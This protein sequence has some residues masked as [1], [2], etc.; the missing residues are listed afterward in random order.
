MSKEKKKHFDIQNIA[1]NFTRTGPQVGG[2]SLDSA[3][4]GS[5]INVIQRGFITDYNGDF[6]YTALD[7]ISELFLFPWFKNGH[8]ESEIQNCLIQ[9]TK[10]NKILV[11][12][13]FPVQMDILSK[14]IAKTKIK[15]GEI[16]SSEDVANIRRIQF[17]NISI[18]PENAI[19]YIFPN[20]WRR[21]LFFDF[22]PLYQQDYLLNNLESILA[23]CHVYLFYPEIFRIFP[24]NK[25]KL[26]KSG[27][28]PFI[29]LLGWRYR[30]ITNAI[31]NNILDILLEERVINSF[32]NE[33]ILL[34]FESWMKKELFSAHKTI[35]RKGIDEYLE[36]DFIS[37]IHLLYPRIEGLMQ[38][39]Y[40]TKFRE[41]AQ[42]KQLIDIL[43]EQAKTTTESQ[44]IFLPDEF[45]DYLK[46][47]F[48]KQFDLSKN[49]CEISRTS[50]AHGVVKEDELTKKNAFLG[51]LILD[52]IYYYT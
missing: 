14:R 15:K 51:I 23:S 41:K 16:I 5:K 44:E 47:F 12:L 24:L 33:E 20:R 25:D 40:A 17:P 39:L 43:T 37:S 11:N 48:F 1:F 31:E 26:F 19:I 35:I 10:D 38:H 2:F 6:F 3:K 42:T 32:N 18:N 52:Q 50:V 45:N 9:I 30:T 21:G 36:G 7:Q 13:N 4:R 22:L 27:W 28:F 8:Y 29:R 46:V 49:Q 34:M